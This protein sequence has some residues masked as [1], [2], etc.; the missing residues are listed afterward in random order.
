MRVAV[1]G[2]GLMGAAIARRLDEVGGFD[3]VLWN[4]TQARAE[5]LGFGTVAQTPA[6][7]VLGADLIVTSLLDPKAM[8]SVF[9]G[10]EGILTSIANQLVLETST[11]GPAVL[12]ELTGLLAE[13]GSSLID[14][15]L[16]GSTGAVLSGTLDIILGGD[17]SDIE[18]AWPVISAL[19]EARRV[20]KVGDAAQLKLVHNTMLAVV[21]AI[22]AEVLVAAT[23]AGIDRVEAFTM[24]TRISPYMKR[25]EGG[26]L[27]E[28][29]NSVS[30]AMTGV[31][32]DLDLAIDLFHD[33]DAS[34][35]LTVL[36]RELYAEA[37]RENGDL[38]MSAIIRRYQNA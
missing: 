21:S 13:K 25:R 1:I 20:G 12:L 30:F 31:V 8:R 32:K 5:E 6:A 9:A 29:F 7:A 33:V 19:G 16:L 22:T 10:T 26:F 14:S 11:G 27:H 24:L 4:R 37:T 34:M 18:R 35:P 2:I 3:L 36:A 17:D 15:P 23:A 28:D 38:D